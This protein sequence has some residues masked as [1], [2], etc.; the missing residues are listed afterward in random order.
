[1]ALTEAGPRMQEPVAEG[2]GG[3]R[4]KARPK[5]AFH[6]IESQVEWMDT[7][8]FR[9]PHAGAH[10]GPKLGRITPFPLDRTAA[11]AAGHR[12]SP[13]GGKPH[14]MALSE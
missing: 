1:M 11:D 6:T 10:A 4:K 3:A 8:S 9:M 2:G 5:P 12:S 7:E 14:M 13:T